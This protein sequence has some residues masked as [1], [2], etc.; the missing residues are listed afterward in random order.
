MNE[1]AFPKNISDFIK[2]DFDKN[3]I[4]YAIQQILSV[5]ELKILLIHRHLQVFELIALSI[6]LFGED[7]HL[8]LKRFL[9]R[10]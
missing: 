6:Y 10:L 8:K 1:R 5:A 3:S 7:L 9:V 4:S 2:Q